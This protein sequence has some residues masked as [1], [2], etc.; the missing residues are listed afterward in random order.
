MKLAGAIFDLDGTLADTLP[1]CYAAFRG[2]CERLDGPVYTDEQI[3]GLLGPSE[4]G[5][6]QRA[7]P[8][9]WEEGLEI[10]LAEYRRHLGLCPGL[11]P[12]VASA[13]ALLRER[14]VPLGLV[15]GKGVGTAMMSL[16]HF[17]LDG[18]FEAVETGSPA[19]IVKG[20]AIA[21]VVARWD[22]PPSSVIYVGDAVGDMQ[23]AREAGV[24]P[25]AAAWAPSAIAAELEATRPHALFSNASDFRTWVVRTLGPSP[26]RRRSARSTRAR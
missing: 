5:M 26:A 8:S 15:T 12:A 4:E 9:R 18:V 6:L 7:M 24:L 14:K 10:L 20:A 13:L 3:R 16:A 23:A 25:V 2:A 1:V 19:G 22:V 11:F 21:R 17:G